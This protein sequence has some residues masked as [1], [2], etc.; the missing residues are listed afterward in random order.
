M[1]RRHNEWE[2]YIEYREQDDGSAVIVFH[3][4][5]AGR[6]GLKVGD[7]LVWTIEDAGVSVRKRRKNYKLRENEHESFLT[8]PDGRL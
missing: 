2:H 7:R 3:N 1:T 6:I 8:S 5:V 4:D